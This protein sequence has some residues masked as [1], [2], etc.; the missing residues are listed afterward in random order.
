MH[1]VIHI[2]VLLGVLTNTIIYRKAHCAV[3]VHCVFYRANDTWLYQVSRR[4]RISTLTFE[5]RKLFMRIYAYE[6]TYVCKML[7]TK[8]KEEYMTHK[9]FSS[10]KLN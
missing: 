9:S 1:L 4:A 7:H 10:P 2:R 6:T 5:Y 8:N 3:F